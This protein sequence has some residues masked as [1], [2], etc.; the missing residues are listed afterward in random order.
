MLNND[1]SNME[2][3]ETKRFHVPRGGRVVASFVL[4]DV[5]GKTIVLSLIAT[6]F[7]H[8]LLVLNPLQA[9]STVNNLLEFASPSDLSPEILKLRTL[10]K[11]DVHGAWLAAQ[12]DRSSHR[13]SLVFRYLA[14]QDIAEAFRDN[15]ALRLE[16]KR[17]SQES[18]SYYFVWLTDIV[19][20]EFGFS[21]HGVSILEELSKRVPKTCIIAFSS[22]LVTVLLALCA[23]VLYSLRRNNLGVSVLHFI[24]YSVSSLPAFII[25]YFLL[26][27]FRVVAE[28]PEDMLLP[29]VA[30]ALGNGLLAELLVGMK[31]SFEFEYGRNYVVLAQ[32][33]GL[34]NWQLFV[35]HI[36]RNALIEVLPK[37]GQKM[38]F[39]VSGTIIVE[40]VFNVNGLADML[41]DG[42]GSH[43]NARVLAVILVATL[44]VRVG[45]M[46]TEGVQL[47]LNPKYLQ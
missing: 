9:K 21:R 47:F 19:R 33:R 18:L 1:H 3:T 13:V 34:T 38:A 10:A 2:V 37:I 20:G 36:L 41:I 45:S 35:R 11:E 8:V 23:S 42:L 4:L 46:S 44:L 22:L 27:V 7:T 24:F 28:G 32:A 30:L 29:V 6:F 26:R 43:D 5:I 12:E 25:G 17:V 40:K 16:Q 15:P 14:R 39:V 31:S